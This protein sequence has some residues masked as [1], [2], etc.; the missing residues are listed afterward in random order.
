ML[1]DHDDVDSPGVLESQEAEPSGAPART[2]AH[3]STFC[4]FTELREIIL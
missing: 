4:Y 1:L 2:I 3:N